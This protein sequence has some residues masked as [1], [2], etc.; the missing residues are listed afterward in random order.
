MW[1]KFKTKEEVPEAFRDQYEERDGEWQAKETDPDPGLGDAG[2]AALEAERKAR[3]AAEDATKA[4]EADKAELQRKMDA[5]KAGITDDQLTK[6]REDV[7]AD[8]EKEYSTYK[9]DAEELALENRSLKLDSQVKKL[10]AEN[11]VR[12]E[13]IE[14]WWRQFG[15]RFDLTDDGK[16]MVKDSPGTEVKKFIEGDLKKE[17]PDFYT[18]TQA[19]GGG[20][21]GI[22]RD[23]KLVAGTGSE[24]VLKNPAAALEAA[25]AAGG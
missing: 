7:R 24:D 20:A 8:M 5:Q 21:G 11:G 2:K 9:T 17:L 23:G 3:K 19:S 13:R 18:G 16:P 12:G 25:R 14:A 10:A 15:D 1:P 6:L 22:Q 4:A